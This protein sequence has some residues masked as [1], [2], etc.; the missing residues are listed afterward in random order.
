LDLAEKGGKKGSRVSHKDGV[1]AAEV[2][3]GKKWGQ[4][5]TRKQLFSNSGWQNEGTEMF[6]SRKKK[7]ETLRN[8]EKKKRV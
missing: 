3:G 2:H 5:N 1:K 6:R 8:G 7:G 4:K